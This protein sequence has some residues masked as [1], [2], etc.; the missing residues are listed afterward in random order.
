VLT[1]F[2]NKYSLAT[3]H[4][5][6]FNFLRSPSK[7]A[8]VIVSCATNGTSLPCILCHTYGMNFSF[9]TKFVLPVLL[10]HSFLFPC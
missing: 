3:V 2:V 5:F 8:R 1:R 9:V 10:F 7:R 4:W 6:L